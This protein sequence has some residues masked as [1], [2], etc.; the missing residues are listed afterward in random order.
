MTKFQIHS[1]PYSNIMMFFDKEITNS[2]CTICFNNKYTMKLPLLVAIASSSVISQIVFNDITCREFNINIEKNLDE[3]FY[4]KM[5]NAVLMKEITL[6]EEELESFFYFGIALGNSSIKKA[7]K[8]MLISTNIDEKSVITNVM[9]KIILS[10]GE[11]TKEAEFLAQSFE[12][13]KEKIYELAKFSDKSVMIIELILKSDKLQLESEDSLLEFVLSLCQMNKVYEQLFEYVWLEYCTISKIKLF[14]EYMALNVF[15]KGYSDGIT[16]CLSRKLLQKTN[17]MISP[18]VYSY[19]NFFEISDD[20]PL[21][22]IF[23]REDSKG[24][25]DITAS[26]VSN[27][28][29]VKLVQAD[30]N[31]DFYTKDEPNSW[32]Q[33]SLKDKKAF[34][35]SKYMI[36]ARKSNITSGIN[37]LQTWKLE[38]LRSLDNKWIIIDTQE[39]QRLCKFNIKIYP[40]SC[41]EKLTA[42]KITQTG[43]SSDGDNNLGINAFDIFGLL[44][45]ESI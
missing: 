36:R 13:M 9:R 38:G 32:I 15:K 20:D 21:N 30:P 24:N 35:I 16:K 39:N 37:H 40:V 10:D 45:K 12:S 18:R 19:K 2:E 22:G 17:T 25:V 28:S 34:I 23:R 42:V 14:I 44:E 33:A 27:G 6:Q 8:N 5:E 3:Q 31:N 7:I 29:A 4:R 43:P 41:K 26:S 1:Q 11:Y